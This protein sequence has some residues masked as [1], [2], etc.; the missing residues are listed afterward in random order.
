MADSSSDAPGKDN[1]ETVTMNGRSGTGSTHKTGTG[2][3]R[4]GLTPGQG[5]A[6]GGMALIA[7]TLLYHPVKSRLRILQDRHLRLPVQPCRGAVLYCDLALGYMEHSGIYVGRE[8]GGGR[9]CIVELS[10]INGECQIRYVTPEEFTSAGTA[11]DIWVSCHGSYAAGSPEVAD[12]ARSMVGR[13]LG[14]YR[15][16]SNNCHNFTAWCLTGGTSQG[17]RDFR[18]WADTDGS[19]GTPGEIPSH[20]HNPFLMTL[21]RHTE[22][23]LNAD[24][25]RI[26]KYQEETSSTPGRAPDLPVAPRDA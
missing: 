16:F 18:T 5:L 12:F 23:K 19:P 2:S 14:R 8:P 25:W 6:A 13:N 10:R 15:L 3:G 7:L 9:R 1:G 22:R 20:R 21:K 4:S 24:N 17:E 11:E 26:W